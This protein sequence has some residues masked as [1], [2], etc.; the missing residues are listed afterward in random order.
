[1]KHGPVIVLLVL[2]CSAAGVRAQGT[3]VPASSTSWPWYV[4]TSLFTLANLAEDDQPPHFYQVNIG[5]KLTPKDRL[6]VEA[7][8]WRYYHPLGIPWGE[9]R[10]SADKAYPGHVREFGVGVEYQRVLTKGFY[11]S[12]SAIPFFRRYY[13]TQNEKIGNGLQLY[14]TARAGYHVGLSDRLF[15]EPSIAFNY[16]PISTN[17]PDAFAAQDERWPSYFLAEPGLN[18]GFT[19]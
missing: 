15:L 9:S 6:S 7:I 14:L 5:Y 18:V 1:M 3:S 13:D 12:I 4:G 10:E 17:V 16:W 2:T 8:T 19:F 11:S